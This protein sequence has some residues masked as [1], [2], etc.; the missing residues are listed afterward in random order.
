MKEIYLSTS[1]EITDSLVVNGAGA[2]IRG[3]KTSRLFGISGGT[4]TFDRLTFTDGYPL[5]DSGG[6]AYIDSSAAAV[7]FVNCTFFGNR[8]GKSGAAGYLYGGGN[9]QTTFTN[10]TITNNRAAESGGGVAVLGGSVQFTSSIVT[11]NNAPI[12]ED[13]HTSGG[14][15]VNNGWYN[16]VG[17]TN[18]SGSF[19]ASFENDLSVAA[20]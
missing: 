18:A 5:S 3:S 17:K 2:L 7:D 10:C 1:I 14:I 15:V 19:S 13:I 9:R 16:V 6:A 11:G 8:A 4:V 12:D 20:S